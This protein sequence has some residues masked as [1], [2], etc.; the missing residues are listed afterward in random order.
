MINKN[1]QRN[2]NPKLKYL[3]NTVYY[4]Q[5][6]LMIC[7]YVCVQYYVQ[8]DVLY[9]NNINS[10]TIP[11]TPFMFKKVEFHSEF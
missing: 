2:L 8:I 7:I 4:T 5:I 11:C 1:K 9:I 10:M 6:I 3:D